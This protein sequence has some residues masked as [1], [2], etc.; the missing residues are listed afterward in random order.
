MRYCLY[1]LLFGLSLFA[2]ENSNMVSHYGAEDAIV[3]DMVN[4]ITGE[5]CF[6]RLDHKLGGICELPL[7]IFCSSSP[8]RTI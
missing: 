8:K 6:Q 7:E 3:D 2:N 1:F 4:A 5:L